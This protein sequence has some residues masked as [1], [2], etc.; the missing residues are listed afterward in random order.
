MT[1][2]ALLIC[3]IVI[4]VMDPCRLEYAPGVLCR[5]SD[6]SHR[7]AIPTFVAFFKAM[8]KLRKDNAEAAR[9]ARVELRNFKYEQWDGVPEVQRSPRKLFVILLMSALQP[10][11]VFGP[12]SMHCL[13]TVTELVALEHMGDDT[14]ASCD[15]I[16]VSSG[17]QTK[18]SLSVLH[19]RSRSPQTAAPPAVIAPG[20]ASSSDELEARLWWE[21][22]TTCLH[23]CP[24]LQHTCVTASGTFRSVC[25]PLARVFWW[26]QVNRAKLVV[27]APR[28]TAV[29]SLCPVE[30]ARLLVLRGHS[31][32]V[33]DCQGLRTSHRR[34]SGLRRWQ[35]EPP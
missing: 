32:A 9:M 7:D 12:K 31:R 16:S 2:F 34:V 21:G 35:C 23:A 26:V 24:C 19:V 27:E 25:R 13:R 22:E 33:G 3:A 6:K 10:G 18:Y 1:C 15:S 5:A 8:I 11:A 20:G 28:W 17:G 4:P 14:N 30:Q 29:L